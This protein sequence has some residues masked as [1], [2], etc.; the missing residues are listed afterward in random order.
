MGVP[1][2]T[3][4][5]LFCTLIPMLI[6]LPPSETKTAGGTGAPLDLESLSFPDL[7]P[8]RE[9][10]IADLSG[11]APD[12]ALAI[13]GISEK[14][15][16]EA[17]ANTELLTAPTMPAVFRYSGVLFDALSAPTLEKSALGRLAIGSALF[18]IIRAQDHIPHYRLSGGTKVPDRHG[19]TPTMKARWGTSITGVLT[20]VDDL[21]VDLRSGSYQQ[22]GRVPGAVTVRV[23]SV[24]AD[25]S[26][27]VVSHFNKHYKG[28]LARVLASSPRDAGSS[29][30]VAEIARA[31]G[32][33][34]EEDTPSRETLTLVV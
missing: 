13:L 26:R 17:V 29:A 24:M 22:L 23:E 2:V 11:I 20:A 10:I 30:E 18:G 3:G 8:A 4:A 16:P 14:L 1:R 15:R 5:H 31:A 32:M 33:T 34:V 27:K 12:D 19:S 9:S 6:L 7:N 21:I 25:G 28:E